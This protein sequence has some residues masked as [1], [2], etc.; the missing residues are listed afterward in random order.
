MTKRIAALGLAG[1]LIGIALLSTA[2]RGEE[3]GKMT[4]PEGNEMVTYYLGMLKRGPKWTPERT[5]GSAEIQ[6]GHMAHMQKT[7]AEGKL[8]VAGPIA[9]DGD[10]RG[11]LVYKVPTLDEARALAEA[12]PAVKSGRLSVEL[13]PWMVQKG[14][15]P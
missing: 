8:V 12:D 9:D 6:K 14:V 15:L 5:P 4:D 3:K 2:A 10:L 1:T 7:H 13:H 11:I